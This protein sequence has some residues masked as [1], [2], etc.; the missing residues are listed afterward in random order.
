MRCY[1][2]V[3]YH[4]DLSALHQALLDA[5]VEAVTPGRA[6]QAPPADPAGY[7]LP[8][9]DFVLAVFPERSHWETPSALLLDLGVA[10]GKGIPV[11]LI[12]EPQ[13]KIDA[14]LAPLPLATISLHNQAGLTARITQFIS[15]ID[16][17]RRPVGEDAPRVDHRVLDAVDLDL[18]AL[19][20]Q[21]QNPAQSAYRFE[22]IALRLLRAAGAEVEEGQ[23][24][25]H[26][27]DAAGW[28]PGTETLFP[29]PLLFEFK[30]LRQPRVE[31][32]TLAQLAGYVAQR[33]AAFGVMICFSTTPATVKWPDNQWPTVIAFEITDL[34]QQLRTQTL[35]ALLRNRR[36]VAVHGGPLG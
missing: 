14:S 25:D 21:P 18:E 23:N 5:N 31:S 10:I 16:S 8:E 33:G 35:A 27:Y 11:L 30:L 7:W 24:R 32:R 19:R 17:S 4:Y 1:L 20:D 6:F 2:V 36:N 9:V 15:Q 26:G 3:E 12:A 29:D 22:E 34:V 28:V 13:R